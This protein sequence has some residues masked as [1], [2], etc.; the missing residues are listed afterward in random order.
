MAKLDGVFNAA[1][2]PER[3]E[4]VPVP[5][6][7]YIAMIVADETTETKKGGEMIVLEIDIQE[8]EH[9]GRKI[10]ENLN[11]KND[12][13]K[14]V[15]IAYRT[16]A[17]IVKAVGKQSIKDTVELHNKRLLIT[18]KVE[19]P[20]PYVDNN[21]NEQAGRA[22]NRITKFKPLAAATPASQK[23]SVTETGTEEKAEGT[24]AKA[25]PSWM[26]NKKG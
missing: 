1:D 15:D 18:V 19:P 21:G 23:A 12:N 4:F 24:T 13:P 7:E 9:Q 2:V 11:I 5:P 3:E 16:L 17:E 6:G 10:F 22:Q 8:G 26:R 20:K 25:P 14:A